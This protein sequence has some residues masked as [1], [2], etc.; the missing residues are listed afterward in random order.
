M[1]SAEIFTFWLMTENIMIFLWQCKIL[2][3][4]K[5]AVG[6]KTPTAYK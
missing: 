4:I 6:I 5:K 3:Q 2:H 1:I